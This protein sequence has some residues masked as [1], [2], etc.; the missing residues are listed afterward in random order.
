M[1]MYLLLMQISITKWFIFIFNDVTIESMMS[2][3]SHS[4]VQYVHGRVTIEKLTFNNECVLKKD[5]F[6]VYNY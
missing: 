1:Y 4:D 6:I 2:Q 5:K 3:L